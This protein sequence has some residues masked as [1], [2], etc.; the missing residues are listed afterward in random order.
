[1]RATKEY[2][3]R[4]FDEFN[5]L[6]FSGRLPKIPVELSNAKTFMGKC[7]YRRRRDKWGREKKYDF[8]M[9]IS[10]RFDLPEE[11]IDDIIIHEM[12]HYYIGVSQLHDTSSHGQLFKQMMNHINEKYHR[13]VAIT[14]KNDKLQTELAN[15]NRPRWH[16]VARV[17]LADGH[18]GL[19]VLPRVVQSIL[20]FYN[21]VAR[22]NGVR[23]VELFMSNDVFFNRYPNSSVPK[24]HF[25]DDKELQQHL[26]GA[27]RMGCD[28]RTITRNM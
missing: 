24:V 10:A 17:E 7:V 20:K 15:D 3:E 4:K 9:R 12:I 1:M 14:Y 13:H 23:R 18:V 26:K 27:E 22:G 5:Q 6:M 2:V 25:I 16:V 11:E 28:G 8:K 21:I 19:K